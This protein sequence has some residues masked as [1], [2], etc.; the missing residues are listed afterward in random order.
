ML[1]SMQGGCHKAAYPPIIRGSEGST[2]PYRTSPTP[3]VPLRTANILRATAALT[4]LPAPGAGRGRRH[5]QDTAAGFDHLD[6]TV[7]HLGGQERQHAQFGEPTIHLRLRMMNRS[8]LWLWVAGIA[9]AANAE[10]KVKPT[11]IVDGKTTSE[12]IALPQPS[13]VT[14]LGRLVQRPHEATSG[15]CNGLDTSQLTR[16]Y[17]EGDVLAERSSTVVGEGAVMQV[18]FDSVRYAGVT[19]TV[20]VYAG[21]TVKNSGTHRIVA[22]PRVF[23]RF[24]KSMRLLNSNDGYWVTT[25]DAELLK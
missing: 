10:P 18:H 2:H 14:K 15:D 22:D 12:A 5:P 1:K 20:M 8:T 3:E 13:Q 25:L 24:G 11:W 23:L 21:C 7:R 4:L 17:P 6:Q 16:S 9:L 19:S